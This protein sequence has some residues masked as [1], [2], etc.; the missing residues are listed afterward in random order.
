MKGPCDIVAADLHA[1][2]LP[3]GTELGPGRRQHDYEPI[4]G[5]R[6][7]MMPVL[8]RRTERVGAALVFPAMAREIDSPADEL[9][10]D[11]ARVTCCE[12]GG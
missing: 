11:G 8:D 4:R 5:F 9:R 3:T 6:T 2:A 7:T 10:A 1:A 12:R